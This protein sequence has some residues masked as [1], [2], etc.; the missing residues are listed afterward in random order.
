MKKKKKFLLNNIL[1]QKSYVGRNGVCI[2]KLF[3][4]IATFLT[5]VS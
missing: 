5:V 3:I 2:L 1:A 4:G